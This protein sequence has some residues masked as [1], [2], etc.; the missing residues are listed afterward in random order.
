MVIYFHSA[1]SW[2]TEAGVG[3]LAGQSSGNTGCIRNPRL[4]LRSFPLPL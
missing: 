4:L 1:L 2:D 3:D